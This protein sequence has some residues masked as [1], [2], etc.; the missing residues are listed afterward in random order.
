[1]LAMRF[2]LIGFSLVLVSACGGARMK[3]D[4]VQTPEERLAQEEKAAEEQEQ[5]AQLEGPAD[6]GNEELESDKK[7]QFDERQAKIELAR[8]ARSAATCPKSVSPEEGPQPKG[9]AEVTLVFANAGHVKSATISGEFGEKAVGKCALRAMKAVIV[10]N[11]SG[12][13]KTMTWPVD[14]TGQAAE[15][16]KKT[17]ASKKK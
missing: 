16:E 9:Q 3:P 8:A 13:E 12:P 10:P 6:V 14:L 17:D 4:P 7:A 5:K 1:M 2:L 11:F 15:P